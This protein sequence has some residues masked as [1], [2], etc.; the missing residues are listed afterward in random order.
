M[1]LSFRRL[2]EEQ[3]QLL[4]VFTCV[5]PEGRCVLL[6]DCVIGHV[7]FLTSKK[8]E[9]GEILVPCCQARC[10]SMCVK[11]F[12]LPIGLSELGKE[13]SSPASP[14]HRTGGACAHLV[15][16]LGAERSTFT[17]D[18]HVWQPQGQIS[19]VTSAFLI[20]LHGVDVR[21]QETVFG[22]NS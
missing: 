9:R 6:Y 13:I 20:A 19:F 10:L 2:V 16:A 17:D 7:S 15:P 14:R 3:Y 11:L 5:H 21:A 4:V 12:V 8:M 22:M 1:C 18:L